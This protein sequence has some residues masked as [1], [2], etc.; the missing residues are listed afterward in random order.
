MVSLKTGTALT[1]IMP[2]TSNFHTDQWG[3]IMNC[4]NVACHDPNTKILSVSLHSTY[5]QK[6]QRKQHVLN[7]NLPF[8]ILCLIIQISPLHV[9]ATWNLHTFPHP[10]RLLTYTNLPLGYAARNPDL[11]GLPIYTQVTGPLTIVVIWVSQHCTAW[12]IEASFLHHS[13]I[14]SACSS[15][16]ITVHA[17]NAKGQ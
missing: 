16:H 13:N 1:S 7:I 17:Y 5:S 3:H 9:Q 2:K 8:K 14:S 12:Q 6:V 15:F 10:I 4:V 11:S